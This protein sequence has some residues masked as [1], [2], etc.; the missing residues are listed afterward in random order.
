[1]EKE[2][3]EAKSLRWLANMEVILLVVLMVCVIVFTYFRFVGV[4]E[5]MNQRNQAYE[6]MIEHQMGYN[7]YLNG[8]KVSEEF[9]IKTLE[10]DDYSVKIDGKNIYLNKYY[11][12]Y[13][14]QW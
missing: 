13:R 9:N 3:K 14:R 1:M 6:I 12:V 4:K 5:E 7:I 8:E 10:Y 11:H 2:S